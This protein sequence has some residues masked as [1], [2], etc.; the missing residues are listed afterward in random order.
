MSKDIFILAKQMAG[1]QNP[2]VSALLYEFCP[3]AA[4]WYVRG[5]EPQEVFDVVWKAFEDYAT[6]RSLR[7]CL[8]G[9]GLSTLVPDVRAYMDKVKAVRS[10]YSRDGASP[11]ITHYME[12]AFGSRF[13]LQ[14]QLNALGGTLDDLKHYVRVWHVLM[15]D[16]KS[17]TK[18]SAKTTDERIF[19]LF[20]VSL[21]VPGMTSALRVCL[22]VWGWEVRTGVARI[23]YLGLLVSNRRQPIIRFSLVQNSDRVGDKPWPHDGKPMV[24]GLDR[25]M[26][27]AD[28]ISVNIRQALKLVPRWHEEAQIGRN[29]PIGLDDTELCRF[30]GYKTLCYGRAGESHRVPRNQE[31]LDEALE[32]LTNEPGRERRFTTRSRTPAAEVPHEKS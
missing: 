19:Q 20:T 27:Y 14:N 26:G 13:G 12:E 15:R 21:S 1:K 7:Q 32:Q 4:H 10:Q 9:Y 24:F 18:M 16:W 11:E 23:V 2:I 28:A 30:C 22:P 25:D 29:R 5:A 17:N 6:G 31:I 3:A 8:E